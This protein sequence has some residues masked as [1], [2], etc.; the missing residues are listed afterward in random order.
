VPELPLLD[1][2]IESLRASAEQ[3]REQIAALEATLS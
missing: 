3:I 1:G 2:E